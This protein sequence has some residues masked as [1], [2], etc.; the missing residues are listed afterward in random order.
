M[1]QHCA[2]DHG[3]AL[4][5]FQVLHAHHNRAMRVDPRECRGPHAAGAASIP[6]LPEACCRS[7][8]CHVIS[9]CLQGIR[10]TVDRK[11]AHEV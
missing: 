1:I 9:I 7:H 2:T 4:L 3:E 11:A 6:R 10:K 8:R 5:V